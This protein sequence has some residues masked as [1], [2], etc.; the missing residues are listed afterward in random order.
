MVGLVAL[1]LAA[2]RVPATRR[3]VGILW[4]VASFWPRSAHPLAA[5]CYAERAVPDLVTRITWLRLRESPPRVVLA[6]HSQGTVISAAV[7]LQLR[8]YDRKQ[9]GPVLSGLGLLTF[10]CVLRRL[11]GRYFPV[12]FGPDRMAD[13]ESILTHDPAPDALPRWRNLW[14]YT[15]YLGGQVTA[16]PPPVVPPDPAPVPDPSQLLSKPPVVGPAAWEWHSPDPLLFD[17]P[18][19]STTYQPTKR[20]SDFWMDDSGYFQLA[21]TDLATQLGRPPVPPVPPVP[22]EPPSSTG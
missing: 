20:H 11:Y 22:Q 14:R 7:L 17:R 1:A 3:S 16:G 19:G 10:G 4:D 21:V 9:D 8:T 13:L 15:D 2:F 12:Y 6:A 5:P 18:A